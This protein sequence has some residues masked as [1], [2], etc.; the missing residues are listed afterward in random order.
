YRKD[1]EHTPYLAHLVGVATLVYDHGGDEDAVIAAL[2]HDVLEDVSLQ[3]AG[4]IKERF[5]K[6]VLE[7]V[8]GVSEPK[9]PEKSE[10]ENL[11]WRQRKEKYLENLETDLEESLLVCAADKYHNWSNFIAGYKKHGEELT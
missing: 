8:E 7:I 4:E 10:T 3:K 5:G 2:L 11:S 1:I 9:D 6:K